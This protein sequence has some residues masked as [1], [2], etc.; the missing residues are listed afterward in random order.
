MND[1]SFI[2]TKKLT[3]SLLNDLNIQIH[4]KEN[5]L[6]ELKIKSNTAKKL[7]S[8]S[9]NKHHLKPIVLYLNNKKHNVGLCNFCNS[10]MIIKRKTKNYCSSTCRSQANKLRGN[11]NV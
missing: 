3:D 11:T 2:N 10:V 6:L 7:I 8:L 9:K 1:K 5:E 4:N